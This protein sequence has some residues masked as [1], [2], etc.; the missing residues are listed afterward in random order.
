MSLTVL[1]ASAALAFLFPSQATTAS[2]ALLED[3]DQRQFLA[4][5]I[6]AWEVL[7][8]LLRRFASKPEQAE[9]G[10]ER[11]MALPI[12][13]RVAS[14]PTEPAGLIGLAAQYQLSLFDAAYLDLALGLDAPLATRDSA[15]L[16]AAEAAL[17]SV[18]DLR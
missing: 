7:H 14:D 13:T 2:E 15:L 10:F 9:H 6:F 12:N 8:V 18:L 4:P 1:D 17:I 16:A 11:L 3:A 5:P